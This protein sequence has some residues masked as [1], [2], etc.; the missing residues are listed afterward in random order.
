MGG[1]E[2]TTHSANSESRAVNWMQSKTAWKLHV[3]SVELWRSLCIGCFLGFDARRSHATMV[4]SLSIGSRSCASLVFDGSPWHWGCRRSSSSQGFSHAILE[5]TQVT[6]QINVTI[7]CSHRCISARVLWISPQHFKTALG[8][9]GG[10][11]C[12][13]PGALGRRTGMEE[14]SYK[15]WISIQH[16]LYFIFWMCTS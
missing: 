16:F 8:S 9:F 7:A 10:Q 4:T 3:C 15:G 14:I 5:E 1:T 6:W 11:P 12:V 2:A 13:E